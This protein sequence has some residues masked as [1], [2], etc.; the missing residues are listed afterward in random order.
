MTPKTHQLLI[1]IGAILFLIALFASIDLFVPDFYQN[2][3]T[4]VRDRNIHGI[5]AYIASF[6]YKAMIIT[7]LLIIVTN[8]IGLPSI[9]VLTVSGHIFGLV[10]GILLC[11]IG[12]VI[13]NCTAFFIIRILFR[14]KAH[15]LIEKNKTLG[16]IDSYS[17][18]KEI[19]AARLIPFSPNVLITTLGALSHLSFRDHALATLAGKLPSVAFEVWIGFD[20]IRFAI[21]GYRMTLLLLLVA[22]AIVVLS[23][24]V[25]KK[26][27]KK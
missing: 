20:L 8:M 23:I 18:F 22:A 6:G 16:K 14:D 1:K 2:L 12:E 3:F 26:K 17:N 21:G 19:F 4:M 5:A 13:G 11:W 25:Y 10:P 27:Q 24:F 15:E 7:V 9:E